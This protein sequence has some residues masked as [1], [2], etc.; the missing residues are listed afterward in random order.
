[1]PFY[2]FALRESVVVE[3]HDFLESQRFPRQPEE[4]AKSPVLHR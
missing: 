2:A 4:A 3:C 1:M